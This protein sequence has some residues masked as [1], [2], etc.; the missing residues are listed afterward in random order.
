MLIPLL[1]LNFKATFDDARLVPRAVVVY[2]LSCPA[3]ALPYPVAGTLQVKQ[4]QTRIWSAP[5]SEHSSQGW[6]LRRC[7]PSALGTIPR[8]LCTKQG[9]RHEAAAW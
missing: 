7:H 9:S 4:G 2:M 1:I 5:A 8:G 6:R 3:F